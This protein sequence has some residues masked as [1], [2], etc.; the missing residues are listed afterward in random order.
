M[1]MKVMPLLLEKPVLKSIDLSKT[2]RQMKAADRSAKAPVAAEVKAEEKK[3]PDLSPEM[4]EQLIGLAASLLNKWDLHVQQIELIQGGQMALVWKVHTDKGPYCLKRIHRPEKKALFSIYAQ[5]YLAKKGSRV[6]G[7]VPTRQDQLYTKHGPFLYLVYDWIEGRPFDLS[8][9]E[10]QAW[11]MKGLAHYHLES[12]GYEPPEGIPVFS[13]LGQWPRHYIKRCRQMESW[14]HIASNATEDPFSELYLA[15]I[16]PHIQ[17]GKQLIERL[18]S[19]H[20]EKWVSACRMKP[21]LCHQDYGTGNTLLSDNR[22]WIIDLDTTTFD[23][24]I[25]DLRKTI[26][27]LMGDQ[28]TWDRDLFHH[29]LASY[30][31]VNPLSGDEKHVMFL[32]MLFPYE[33]Y[34]TANERFGRKNDLP[35]E[36]LQQALDY[37]KR[38]RSEIEPLIANKT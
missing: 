27:P 26:V 5:D 10:D 18:C 25:R 9:P 21:G 15:E 32:D 11:L 7:I 24:P 36:E 1:K 19:S 23:L 13:K 4:R 35:A 30:E 2:E 14:K 3:E 8:V 6:P 16:D 17:Y 28:V 22:I 31:K 34:E 38:K 20:Y 37:E 33:L 12:I 29:L